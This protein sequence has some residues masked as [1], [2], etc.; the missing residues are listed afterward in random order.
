[1]RPLSLLTK[2][3]SGDQPSKYSTVGCLHPKKL[4]VLD[5]LGNLTTLVTDCGKCIHCVDDKRNQLAARMFLHTKATNSPWKHVYFITLTYGS[6][7]L[8]PFICHPA[9]DSWLQTYP[10][11]SDDN[12]NNRLTMTPTILRKEHIVN[13]FKR[14][15]K[16]LPSTLI[17][18]VYC[19]EYGE[20]FKRPHYHAVIWSDSP[21]SYQHFL[22]AWSYQCVRTGNPYMIDKFRNSSQKD[23]LFSFR[24][25][26][27]FVKDLVANGTMNEHSN[28]DINSSSS[29]DALHNFSYVAK[30]IGKS[31][32]N[33]FISPKFDDRIKYIYTKL[34][35]NLNSFDLDKYIIDPRDD[36]GSRIPLPE[37]DIYSDTINITYNNI[38]YENINLF[39]FKQLIQPFIGMSRRYSP[40]K[41]YAIENMSRFEEGNFSLPDFRGKSIPFPRYFSYLLAK[42]KYPLRL[43]KK[44][45]TGTSLTK[46]NLP[47][48]L[49]FFKA[50]REDSNCILALSHSNQYNSLKRQLSCTTQIPLPFGDHKLTTKTFSFFPNNLVFTD[51]SA[52]YHFEYSSSYDHFIQYLYNHHTKEYDPIDYIDRITF[53]DLLID[54]ITK[55][56][57]NVLKHYPDIASSVVL[58]DLIE[59]DPNSDNIRSSLLT[60]RSDKQHKYTIN[61]LDPSDYYK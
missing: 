20:T 27:V 22:K 35:R 8:T 41:Q 18:Y 58:N 17:S 59:S 31:P 37:F 25:G 49:N 7:D 5:S 55:Q 38:S 16:S 23:K 12:Y 4:Q 9:K 34:E 61:H 43:C 28:P 13:F 24:L 21:I 42:H 36:D 54:L 29:L 19:G 47:N 30:Y 11:L 50:F 57:S 6:Y 33:N 3:Y 51:S 60:S 48:L 53:C 15:R 1:M 46:D 14:L 32:L 52:T 10:I 2:I 56:W 44:T 39:Q 45:F 26:N 40:G